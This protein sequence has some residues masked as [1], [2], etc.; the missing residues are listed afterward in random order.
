MALDEILNLIL[1]R[2]KLILL[3]LIVII[4]IIGVSSIFTSGDNNGGQ[5]TEIYGLSFHIPEGFVEGQRAELTNGETVDLEEDGVSLIE[6]SVSAYTYFKES[7][8]IDSKFSKTVN[9]KEGTVYIYKA[10]SNGMA[11][12]Y[13]DHGMRVVILGATFSELEEIII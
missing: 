11:Y 10:P 7:N 12:V 6:I 4:M 9:G 8:Y 1:K 13:Y 2:P 5:V 3:G